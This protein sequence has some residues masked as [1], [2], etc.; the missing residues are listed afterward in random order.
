[1][2]LS[3]GVYFTSTTADR[4]DWVSFS[5]AINSTEFGLQPQ[6]SATASLPTAECTAVS[7]TAMQP[8]LLALASTVTVATPFLDITVAMQYMSRHKWRSCNKFVITD[9]FS[10]RAD[11]TRWF[12]YSKHRCHAHTRIP[13]LLHSSTTTAQ[14]TS[15]AHSSGIAPVGNFY[16]RKVAASDHSI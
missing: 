10:C 1:M 11:S 8:H 6:H 15:L 7:H 9:T 4:N 13:I 14:H 12:T 5:P 3:T 2:S 16:C